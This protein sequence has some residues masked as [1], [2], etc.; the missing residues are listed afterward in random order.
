MSF[1]PKLLAVL[2]VM[3]GAQTA[4][5][6]SHDYI[7]SRRSSMVSHVF[8]QQGVEGE[9][10]AYS[11]KG[12]ETT[13]AGSRT[14]RDS[15]AWKGYNLGTTVGI[16]VIKFVQFTLGHSFIN[17]QHQD[18]R[19]ESLRGSRVQAGLKM[20]FMAPIFN[21]ELGSG[22]TGS[23]LDYQRQLENA[24]F[25]GSGYYQEAGISH[26]LSSQISVYFS[27]RMSKEHLAR[28]AGSSD[29]RDMDTNT[30]VM[31]AGVRIWL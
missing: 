17:M 9:Y 4:L 5:A 1:F 12:V 21:L 13:D 3:F 2:A 7:N 6:D 20:V 18:D 15:Q 29:V 24:M 14:Y 19:L 25:H 28:T 27:A 26:Y 31:G 11:T 8:V 22:L 10:G 16:E 30:T 23:R